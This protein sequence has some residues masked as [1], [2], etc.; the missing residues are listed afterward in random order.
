MA[1]ILDLLISSQ[2]G[3]EVTA[4]ALFEAARPSMLFAKRASLCSGLS[5]FYYGGVMLVDGVLTTIANNSAALALSASSTNY[6]EATRAGVV[7]KNTTGFTPGSIPLYTVTTGASTVT[8]DPVD[9]RVWAAPQCI[10][11]RLARVIASDANITLTQAEASNDIL[12]F[13]S[14]VSLTATRNVVV[15]LAS[16]QWTV[17]NGT[18]GAQSLQF[19]GASG[20]GITVANGKRAIVYSDGTNVVRATADV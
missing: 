14:S 15:P 6:I 13:T 12:D 1:S 3:K 20:T 17:Y 8:G 9:N 4:N 7:S 18:T 5:W 16:K 2:A 10:G 19:I 11:G